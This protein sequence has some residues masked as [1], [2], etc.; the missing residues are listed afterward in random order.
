MYPIPQTHIIT[1]TGYCN[2]VLLLFHQPVAVIQF[3]Q[4]DIYEL[5]LGINVACF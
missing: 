4:E 5:Y 2:P 3:V 1:L